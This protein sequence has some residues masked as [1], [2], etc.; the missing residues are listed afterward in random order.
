MTKEVLA[1]PAR[2]P[3]GR[4]L[5]RDAA[6]SV[7]RASHFWDALV[8][9]GPLKQSGSVSSNICRICIRE[10]HFLALR[11]VPELFNALKASSAKTESCISPAEV[12]GAN[13][14]VSKSRSWLLP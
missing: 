12:R 8:F 7:E 11:S 10:T 4:V 2:E 3:S 14:P 13:S 1:F 9:V 6:W 5:V